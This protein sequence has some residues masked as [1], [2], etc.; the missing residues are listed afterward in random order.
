MA[1]TLPVAVID[2]RG[3]PGDA[4]RRHVAREHVVAVFPEQLAG[5][6]VEAHQALLLHL[7]GAGRVLQVEPIAEDDRAR[8]D[9]RTAPSRPGS[10]RR[11]TRRS[12]ARSRRTRRCAPAPASRASPRRGPAPQPGRIRPTAIRGTRR[13][14][15]EAAIRVLKFLKINPASGCQLPATSCQLQLPAEQLSSWELQLELAAG[16]RKLPRTPP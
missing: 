9:R 11:A 7:A 12:R 6:G 14:E 8:N 15:K 3:R 5:V 16:S 4:V 2:D 10:G 1:K 13:R